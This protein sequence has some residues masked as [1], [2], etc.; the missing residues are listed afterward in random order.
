M[1]LM[2]GVTALTEVTSYDKFSYFNQQNND[3]FAYHS[4]YVSNINNII[5]AYLD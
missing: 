1:I 4:F 5:L 2:H 3:W